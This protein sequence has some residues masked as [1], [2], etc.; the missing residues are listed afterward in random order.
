MDEQ[1]FRIL[2][3]VTA[4]QKDA[5]LHGL[6][7]WFSNAYA[8][9]EQNYIGNWEIY[10]QVKVSYRKLEEMTKFAQG[11]CYGFGYAKEQGSK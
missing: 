10:T 6:W 7:A 11:V 4:E 9:A 8:N 2:S 1:K 3:D 5:I